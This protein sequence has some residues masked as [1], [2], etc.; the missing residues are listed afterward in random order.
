MSLSCGT[1]EKWRV[2][3]A[4]DS[5]A[6]TWKLFL[7]KVRLRKT[8]N[9]KDSVINDSVEFDRGWSCGVDAACPLML[10]AL[11]PAEWNYECNDVTW[12]KLTAEI[13]FAFM[14]R[15]IIKR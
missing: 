13:Y 6:E 4:S 9:K 3:V 2:G 11:V 7:I 1:P 8:N 12:D 15:N 10:W 5:I 14:T